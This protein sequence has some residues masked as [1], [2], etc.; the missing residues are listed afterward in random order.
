[1]RD[2]HYINYGTAKTATTWIFRNLRFNGGK[3]PDLSIVRPDRYMNYFGQSDFTSNFNTNLWQLDSDQLAF[4]DSV[5]THHSIIF[6]NPYYYA[7]SLYNYWNSPLD[8]Q[9]FI[10]SFNLYFDY[11]KILKRLPKSILL[12][13]YDDI[14]NNP[15]SVLNNITDYLEIP[16]V[17]GS[18]NYINKTVYSKT[19]LFNN[20][21]VKLLNDYISKFED[22]I[23]KDLSH[24]KTNV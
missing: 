2:K 19:L 1:M 15:Q 6:R 12:L 24:W 7:N 13:I 16:R 11:T 4:L 3:E 10:N 23:N 18:T 9:Q 22:H 5:S 8:S 20:E 21:T 14:Q 17:I